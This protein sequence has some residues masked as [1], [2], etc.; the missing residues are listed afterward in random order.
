MPFAGRYSQPTKP[1]IAEGIEC[2]QH[3]EIVQLAGA[4]LVP[5]RHGGDLHMV[6][7]REQD[8]KAVSTSPWMIW[9]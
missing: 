4:G 8:F 2:P 6:D 1:S 9:R 7:Q 5:G 3:A